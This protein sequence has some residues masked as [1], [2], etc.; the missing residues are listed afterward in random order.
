MQHSL[1]KEEFNFN[2]NSWSLN[3]EYFKIEINEDD[4]KNEELKGA[5]KNISFLEAPFNLICDV[6]HKSLIYKDL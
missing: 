5:S 4:F 1:K 6:F 2:K 3:Y